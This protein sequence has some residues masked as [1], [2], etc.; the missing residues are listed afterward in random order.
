M[1]KISFFFTVFLFSLVSISCGGD[2]DPDDGN[3]NCSE[4]FSI[5]SEL[6]DEIFAF[7]QAASD[8]GQDPSAE[9][10]NAYKA[11]ANDYLDALE[12]LEDCAREVG[13][14][15]AFNQSLA[16]IQAAFDSLTC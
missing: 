4:S 1:K 3:V 7:A 14:L 16:N 2:D 9:N 12:A 13:Q 6:N 5:N 11:A 15:N 8:Y 10:C